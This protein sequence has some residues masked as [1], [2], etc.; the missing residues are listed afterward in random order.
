[1]KCRRPAVT[2]YEPLKAVH[3]TI[4]NFCNTSARS[5][6]ATA[7]IRI[8]RGWAWCPVPPNTAAATTAPALA[9]NRKMPK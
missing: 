3:T 1:M 8:S 7:T 5:P 4:M 9:P 6:K 2:R